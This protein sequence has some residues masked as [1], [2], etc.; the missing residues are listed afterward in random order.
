[1]YPGIQWFHLWGNLTTVICRP[2]VRWSC[3]FYHS[4]LLAAV[5]VLV[6]GSVPAQD[7]DAVHREELPTLESL[8]RPPTFDELMTKHPFDW[9]VLNLNDSVLEVEALTP[10]PDTFQ[11]R[12]EER[13]ALNALSRRSPE[14]SRRLEELKVLEFILLGGSREYVIKFEAVQQV[15]GIEELMLERTDLLIEEGET[16]KAYDLLQRIENLLPEWKEAAPRFDRLLFKEAQIH[17]KEGRPVAALALLEQIHDRD[18]D[19]PDLSESIG[20]LMVPMITQAVRDADYQRARWLIRRLSLRYP[21]HPVLDEPR[22][23]LSELAMAKLSEAVGHSKNGN[24]R[25]ASQAAGVAGLI[26]P[27]TGRNNTSR[28]ELMARYQVL[29]VGVSS[30][31]GDSPFPLPISSQRRHR[32]LVSV[33]LF[34]ADTFNEVMHYRS[35]LIEEW[36]PQDL[37]RLFTISLRSSQPYWQPQVLISASDVATTLADKLDQS[38]SLFDP[39]LA[40]FISAYTVRSPTKIEIQFSRVPLNLAAL[41]RFPVRLDSADQA[42]DQVGEP[43]QLVGRFQLDSHSETERAYLR[44]VPEP[45]GLKP[46]QYHVAEI[47]ERVYP[48]RHEE[49]QAFRRGDIE[50]LP[51]LQPWEVEPVRESGLAFVQ[52]LALPAN[53]VLV[54]NPASQ[55][56]GSA[57]LRRALSFAVPREMILKRIILQNDVM[58]LGRPCSATWPQQSYAN[59]SLVDPPRFDLR[60]ALMLK[61]A[62][63]EQLRIPVK[64][65]LVAQAKADAKAAGEEWIESAWRVANADRIQAAGKDIELPRLIMLCESDPVVQRAAEKMIEFWGRIGI[66]IQRV[67]ANESDVTVPDWDIM[68]RRVSV[69]EPLL[70]LWSV[71]LTDDSLDV[72]LLRGYPDWLRQDLTRLDYAGSFRVARDSLFRMQRNIAAQ[73]FLI[74]LWEVDQFIAFRRNVTG[75]KEQPISVYDNVQRWVVTP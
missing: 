50:V 73:A 14:E 35:T 42:D 52:Q 23:K 69:E 4:V 56:V 54:F 44:S 48:S 18:S 37:G 17:R 65:K 9:V 19:Y 74:P 61:F 67:L 72:D 28:E 36:D 64:Q 70:D 27:L 47:I 71:L 62:A 34:E 13:A 31:L 10:R 75:Y 38:H 22:R 25:L 26:W 3:F 40:S 15:I 63:Q 41:F 16:A 33:R 7:V 55:N 2:A 24:H 12:T 6:S 11:K 20:Q 8:R 68:Y 46:G 45:D 5:A 59:S 21:E 32:E 51:S 39:R 1:M 29:R 49:I 43:A 58:K 57:Q 66:Q 53:H 30:I 60:L